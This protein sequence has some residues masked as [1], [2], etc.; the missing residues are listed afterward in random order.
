[1]ADGSFTHNIEAHLRNV[2]EE[3]MRA[4]LQFNELRRH[5]AAAGKQHGVFV[6]GTDRHNG[7][8]IVT[9][10]GGVPM[11]VEETSVYQRAVPLSTW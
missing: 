6:S 3:G 9:Y 8:I 10:D 2:V 11:V 5:V 1:M 7:F 4:R